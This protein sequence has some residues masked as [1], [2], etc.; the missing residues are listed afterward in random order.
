MAELLIGP[1]LR[2]VS[3]T[4]ATVWVALA[5][6]VVVVAV[7]AF[8]ASRPKLDPN[9]VVGVLILGAVVVIGIGIA[10]AAV[11]TRDCEHHGSEE[12]GEHS[13]EDAS[14]PLPAG[15]TTVEVAP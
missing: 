7:G 1:L 15:P 12:E 5:F 8:V 6:A 10:S 3:E 14:A 11:G 2:Y 9:L 4:E 13:D